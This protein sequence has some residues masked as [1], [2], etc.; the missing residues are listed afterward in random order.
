MLVPLSD[1]GHASLAFSHKNVQTKRRLEGLCGM[2]HTH[3]VKT[4]S[5]YKQKPL[6]RPAD[7]ADRTG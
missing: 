6:E 5:D 2:K 4:G 3:F 1:E 7:I